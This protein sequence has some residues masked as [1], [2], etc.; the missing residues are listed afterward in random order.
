MPILHHF[1]QGTWTSTEFGVHTSGVLNP[2][3]HEHQK[4]TIL[5]KLIYRFNTVDIKTQIN[6]WGVS[7]LTIQKKKRKFKSWYFAGRTKGQDES[8]LLKNK[9]GLLLLHIKIYYNVTI[10]NTV[11]T[12]KERPLEQNRKPRMRHSHTSVL[13]IQQKSYW[14]SGGKDGPFHKW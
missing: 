1:I 14:R 8:L 12:E 13:D 7:N 10:I 5:S 11:Y 6:L 9:G 3:P 2:T 4:M